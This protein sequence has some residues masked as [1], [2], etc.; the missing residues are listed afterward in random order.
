MSNSQLEERQEREAHERIAEYLELTVEELDQLEYEEGDET[1]E[2]GH[3]YNYYLTFSESNPPGIM[4][5]VAH[6]EGRTVYI[7]AWWF[8]TDG[9]EEP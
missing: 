1:S 6:L 5:R 4:G 7:P 8:E 9:P 2:D 3:T